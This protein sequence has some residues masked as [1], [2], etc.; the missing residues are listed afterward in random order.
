[1]NHILD[2]LNPEQIKPVLDTEGAVLVL[3]GAGSGKTRVLTSRIAYL[4]EEKE[5]YPSSILAITFTNKAANEMKER[6]SRMVDGAEKMWICTIHSMCVR[7]LRQYAERIGYNKNFSIYSDTERNN[8]VKKSF[9]ECGYEDE[10]LLKN[11]KFHIANAKTLGLSPEEY[12][13]KSGDVKNIGDICR[14]Y[15]AYQAHLKAYNALDFDDLLTQTLRLLETDKDALEYLSGKFRYIH[16]D[17]F[18]DT[19]RVQYEIVRLLSSVHGNLFCVGDDDQS[20]YGWRGAKIENILEFEKDFKGAKVYKLEQNYRSTKNILKLANTVI[21]N[22]GRRMEKQ[23]WTENGDGAETNYFQAETESDEALYVARAISD[24][25]RGEHYE[26]SDFAVLMRINALTRSFEQEFSKYNIPFKVF[27]GFRFYERKEIKDL[28]A[29]L[30]IINNPFDS[31]A[32]SRVINVPKRGIGA[33]TVET[34]EAHAERTGLSVY[35]AVLAVDELPLTAGS[36]QKVKAFGALL[37]NLV[38]KGMEESADALVRDVINDSGILSMYADDTDESINKKANIDEFVNSVDEFCKLNKGAT[39][40]DFLNQVTLSSDTDEMDEGEYVTLATIHSVK[41]LEF[42]TVFVVGMEENIMP[43][44]RAANSDD[45]L[46][47]ERRLMYVAITRAREHL[48]LT[49]SKS[50]YLYGKREMTMPSRF[51]GELGFESPRSP[52]ESYARRAADSYSSYSRG[53]YSGYSSYGRKF[54]RAADSDDFGYYSDLPPEPQK[55]AP[56]FNAAA[57]YKQAARPAAPSAGAKDLSAFKAGVK[58]RHPKF[59]EGMIVGTKGQGGALVV[60][61]SFPGLGIKA[62]SA[63]L[64]PLTVIE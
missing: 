16:V 38:I 61:V 35:D 17:E 29:Y 43:V 9:A 39:L 22:N 18:Q 6:L 62:L 25:M 33:K 24:L 4:V 63:Q 1:M 45:D 20:I 5:V 2:K 44:S 27:G 7:I 36:K 21:K 60:N 37:K 59:G 13:Q 10:K 15:A 41:G 53:G 14:V 50:R 57:A 48:Y 32:I 42:K 58:V 28:L 52:Y 56:A 11:V 30:R 40:A 23:L 46:E 19:N 34:L 49:R 47:E 55:A 31:E 26:F 54:S 64:A 3:A 12:A 8:V 51:I